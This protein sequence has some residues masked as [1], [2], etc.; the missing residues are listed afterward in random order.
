MD[1]G[2]LEDREQDRR[3]EVMAEALRHAS[4]GSRKGGKR[5]ERRQGDSA[6]VAEDP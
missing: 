5:P 1:D 6:E 2:D 3:A 4:W